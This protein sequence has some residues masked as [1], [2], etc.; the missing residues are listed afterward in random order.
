MFLPDHEVRWDR[1]KAVK[2]QPMSL[3][4][5]WEWPRK[6][7]SSLHKGREWLLD[8]V[9]P[10]RVC[11]QECRRRSMGHRDKFPVHF[12]LERLRSRF[13]RAIPLE[14]ITRVIQATFSRMLKWECPRQ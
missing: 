5:C 3:P 11:N 2:W 6:L 8:N 1:L 12:L 13:H 7:H 10:S 4:R 9:L 14:H